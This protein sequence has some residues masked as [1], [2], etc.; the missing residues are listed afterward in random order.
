[1]RARLAA[2]A[3]ITG[4]LALPVIARAQGPGDVESDTFDG[5][6]ALRQ[7]AEANGHHTALLTDTFQLPSANGV[8]F[9]LEPETPFTVTEAQD[10]SRWV[11]QG[12]VL[13]YASANREPALE[14]ALDI[15]RTG[16][17]NF[18]QVAHAA[19][20]LLAGANNVEVGS[21]LPFDAPSDTQT[22][23][24]RGTG[25]EIAGIEGSIGSGRFYALASTS[26]L[27]N[28]LIDTEDDGALAADF[29]VAAGPGAAVTFDQFHHGGGAGQT[30][31][32]AWVATP[33]GLAIVLEVLLVFGLL[34][35]R[36]RAFGPLIPLRP[37][38]DPSSAEFTSAVAAMLRRARATRPTIT[39][40]L[41]TT[42][43]ALAEQVG[44][45]GS[46]D[47]L[48][49]V[50]KERSPTLADALAQ[51]SLK[52]DAVTDDKTLAGAAAD[53]HRLARPALGE[54]P[55]K[56]TTRRR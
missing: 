13:V 43:A 47:A 2:M 28:E 4:L 17:G 14:T 19:A 15:G 21:A 5:T 50:L 8:L 26:P 51:A 20:P 49:A 42:R 39:R 25:A 52:A 6:S 54:T 3:A 22:V 27:S 48:D 44:I 37:A 12:G 34:T 45:R 33:W 36:G 10:V 46:S 16:T 41:A 1:M 23:Y 32:L 56:P 40:L 9:I 24:L 31:S 30:S 11:S 18:V 29:V 55:P 38:G 35:M 7:L 53:L